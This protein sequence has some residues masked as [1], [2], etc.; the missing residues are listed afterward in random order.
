MGWDG[1]PGRGGLWLSQGFI[2]VYWD[3]QAEKFALIDQVY[4]TPSAP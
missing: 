4:E 3:Y 1:T 2:R